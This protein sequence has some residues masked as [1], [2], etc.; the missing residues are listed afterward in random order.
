MRESR[1]IPKDSVNWANDSGRAAQTFGSV[2][3]PMP[4]TTPNMNCSCWF[5][6]DVSWFWWIWPRASRDLCCLPASIFVSEPY[7]SNWYMKNWR[8]SL[9]S[10]NHPWS[11]RHNGA[12]QA[13]NLPI[14]HLVKVLG[15]SGEIRRAFLALFLGPNQHFGYLDFL[16]EL[17]VEQCHLFGNV[18]GFQVEQR[19]HW[20]YDVQHRIDGLPFLLLE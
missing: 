1:I 5:S 10:S 18:G 11:R 14:G 9:D 19:W 4:T 7:C 8:I 6:V 2:P 20:G 16:E 3:S 15:E 13:S 12:R 17:R